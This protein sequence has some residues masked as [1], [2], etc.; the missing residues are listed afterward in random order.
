MANASGPERFEALVRFGTDFVVPG[1]IIHAI[2]EVCG[3]VRA[4]AN[5]ARAVELAAG[6]GEQA[7]IE[8]LAHTVAETAQKIEQIEEKIMQSVATELVNAEEQFDKAAKAVPSPCAETI[9]QSKATP[10]RTIER[11][12]ASA[13]SKAERLAEI[14]EE[15]PDGRIRYYEK[16]RPSDTPGP[17]R[18]RSYVT[19]FDPK[20]GRV[21]QWNECY[22]HAG[23]VNRVRPTMINGR[24]VSSQHYPAT[25]KD[26]QDNIKGS[27]WRIPKKN[28]D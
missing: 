28:L 22:D 2:G 25:Y 3:A 13:L 6:A 9:N 26:I 1:K 17:T 23:N 14:K 21:R 20:T 16:E 18:G 4:E 5:I 11:A 27:Q 15:L 8:K 7:G 12:K 24:S 10:P 19:E